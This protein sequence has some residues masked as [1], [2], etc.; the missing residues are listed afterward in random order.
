MIPS[1]SVKIFSSLK[2]CWVF[3]FRKG[4]AFSLFCP[5]PSAISRSG[6]L[7]RQEKSVMDW[8]SERL[9]NGA[10]KWGNGL[11]PSSNQV[12]CRTTQTLL[13]VISL[14][15]TPQVS[16]SFRSWICEWSY[17]EDIPHLLSA[18][19]FVLGTKGFTK[20]PC[21]PI[22]PPKTISFSESE[23]RCYEH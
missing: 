13:A 21:F 14:D 10:G 19:D 18:H 2:N 15:Q 6:E 3:L 7:N 17:R 1:L 9:V 11:E 5:P 8:Y 12:L 16:M 20:Y 23:Q 22:F 4:I